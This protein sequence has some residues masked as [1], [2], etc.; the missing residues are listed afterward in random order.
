MLFEDLHGSEMIVTSWQVETD[1]T[2]HNQLVSSIIYMVVELRAERED[3]DTEQG[4]DPS[5]LH[6]LLGW[7]APRVPSTLPHPRVPASPVLPYYLDYW[8]NLPPYL[9]LLPSIQ[10]RSA[11]TSRAPVNSPG[12]SDCILP[13]VTR[14]THLYKKAASESLF[15]IDLIRP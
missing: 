15:S 11:S 4:L 7:A 9:G 10:E 13:R 6:P 12:T 14:D 5:T 3:R 1:T 8:S 2:H